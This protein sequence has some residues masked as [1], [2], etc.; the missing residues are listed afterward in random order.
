MATS[1]LNGQD[2]RNHGRLFPPEELGALEGPD[3]DAW[4]EP[5]RVM[6]S[7]GVTSGTIVADIGAGGGLGFHVSNLLIESDRQDSSMPKIFKEK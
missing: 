6:D 1:Q 5:E 3:R 7:L 2:R 4:Q